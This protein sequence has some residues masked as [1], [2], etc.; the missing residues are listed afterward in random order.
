MSRSVTV[1]QADFLAAGEGAELAVSGP[2]VVR[3][4]GAELDLGTPKARVLPAAIG[5]DIRYVH[6]LVGRLHAA[7]DHDAA[8]RA[9]REAAATRAGIG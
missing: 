2:L 8:G 1:R 4:A 3:H 5:Q 9:D 6:A 7:G